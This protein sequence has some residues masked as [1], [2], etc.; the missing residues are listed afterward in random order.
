ML[1]SFKNDFANSKLTRA[2]ELP[3]NENATT[4]QVSESTA[5]RS[6]GA[7]Q[8]LLLKLACLL[9]I[10]VSVAGCQTEQL[11]YGALAQMGGSTTNVS[12]H[13]EQIIL[14][15]GDVL[16]ITFPSAGNLNTTTPI[17]RDGNIVLALVGEV[18]AVGKTPAELKEELLKLYAGQ[19]DT[20]EITVEVT[21]SS[22]PVFVVGAV[23]RPGKVLT[24]HP[25]TALES[26]MES[27]GFDFTKAN[28]K[29]VTVLR[30][31][32]GRLKS[33]TL[34]M[35]DV[36]DG[37]VTEQFYMKPQD[38]IYVREKFAWF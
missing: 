19:I 37:K 18:R 13:F 27:G 12:T 28:L 5:E 26:V 36:L 21:S 4:Q 9:A 15:E 30:Q 3:A 8:G 24:D 1:L 20:K 17:R 34:N 38:I 23:I 7:I 6:G 22:F 2:G 35:K 11:N 33:Y 31:D 29:K 10:V 14:R 16:K 25:I 32:S